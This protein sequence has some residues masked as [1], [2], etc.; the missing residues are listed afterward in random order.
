MALYKQKG[1][2]MWWYEFQFNGE[3]VRC[4]T[5]TANKRLAEEA[6]RGNRRRME[7]GYN[8]VKR[9]SGPKSFS[10][11]AE[12]YLAIKQAKIAKATL[13]IE[14]YNVSHLLPVFGRKLLCDITA[15]DIRR[16]QDS[17]IASGTA[18]VTINKE[19][20]TLRAILRRNML[21]EH[22]RCDVSLLKIF[23]APG[24]AI[25]KD[26]EQALLQACKESRSR[27]LYVVVILALCTAMRLSEVR[28]LTWARLNLAK[29][30][31]TVGDSKTPTGMG[32]KIMLNNRALDV[33]RTW[34]DQF[35]QRDPKHYV[36]PVEK[37]SGPNPAGTLTYYEQDPTKPI[38]SWKKA[39]ES[40]CRRSGVKIRYHD[41]RHTAITRMLEAGIPLQTVAA[42][43]GWSASTMYLMAKRY[44]H[45]GQSAMRDAVAKLE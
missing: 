15:M 38:G 31:L 34:A 35:P 7:E 20:G 8:D 10:K 40:A 36:F 3:K 5:K 1:S 39:W 32:R 43:V 16:F 14:R 22:L 27:I 25:D 19:V 24:Q 45:I 44:A 2:R 41:L 37:C 9:R 18:S 29:A 13:S 28:F 42:I 6:M 21:W 12:E 23:D 33:L 26:Q 11:A 17:R 4:S 30:E